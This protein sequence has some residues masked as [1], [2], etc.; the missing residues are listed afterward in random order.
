MDAHISRLTQHPIRTVWPGEERDFTPWLAENLDVLETE[1]G[2]PLQLVEREHRVGRYELDLLLKSDDGRVVVVENQFG[3]SDHGHLGKVL[4]YA[5][6]AQ[7]DLVIWL[8]EKFT[9]EHL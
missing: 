4:T 7:A 6:G 9:D 1:V 2:F 5:A 8:A 3:Q